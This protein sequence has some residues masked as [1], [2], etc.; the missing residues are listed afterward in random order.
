MRFLT[1]LSLLFVAID[2]SAGVAQAQVE[3]VPFHKTWARTYGNPTPY[4]GLFD[5]GMAADGSLSVAGLSTTASGA[6]AGWLLNVNRRNGDARSQNLVFNALGGAVDGAGLAA[7]QGAV[8]TGRLIL[9]FFHKHDAWLVRVDR[10]GTPLWS[11]GFTSQGDGRFSLLDAAEYP[12]G[13]WVVAGSTSVQ[14]RP[15]QRAWVVRLSSSGTHLWQYE[16][17]GGVVD[18]LQ[19]VQ[20]TADGGVASVGWTNSSGA[21]MDDLWV[22]KLDA[23]GNLQWQRTFGGGDSDQGTHL[24]ELRGGG[25]AVSGSTRSFTASGYAPWMLRLDSQG[26][27]LWQRAIDGVWGDLQAVAE[28]ANGGLVGV[29]RV[30]EAGFQTNDLWTVEFA[31]NGNLRWQRAY[32]GDSGDWGSA[33]VPL[34]GSE[35]VLGGTWGWGFPEEDLWLLHTGPRGRMRACGLVRDTTF[36]PIAPKISDQAGIA[37]R[38]AA[39]ALDRTVNFGNASASA[40]VTDRCR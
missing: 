40:L 28:T 30:G 20:P 24:V 11:H 22:M 14:D 18:H 32:A 12:D 25:Y 3:K 19:A 17:A 39:W 36:V 4:E 16:Y 34:A 23:A 31:P 35:L 21:G 8:F 10:T 5:L 9:D 37:I 27:L 6:A 38:R 1:L 15:P 29:G 33:I 13:S 2:L 7:D 26:G